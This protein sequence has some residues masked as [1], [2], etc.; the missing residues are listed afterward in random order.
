MEKIKSLLKKAYNKLF[1]R[2]SG[3]EKFRKMF[4]EAYP[5][6]EK[7]I[8]NLQL[9]DLAE[10]YGDIFELRGNLCAT[11]HISAR[12]LSTDYQNWED[13]TFKAIKMKYPDLKILVF[14]YPLA[15]ESIN[16]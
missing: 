9:M 7:F 1:R 5:D 11:G 15:D 12:G 13:E 16:Q 2:K 14:H 6:G 3:R 10:K 8:Q 4:A